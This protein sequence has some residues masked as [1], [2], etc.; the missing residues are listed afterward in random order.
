[1]QRKCYELIAVKL[2]DGFSMTVRE[3]KGYGEVYPHTAVCEGIRYTFC[4]QDT[5]TTKV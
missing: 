2:G 5:R 1:M 3:L 4:G